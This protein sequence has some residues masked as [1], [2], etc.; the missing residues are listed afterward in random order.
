MSAET[1]DDFWAYK[2][3]GQFIYEPTGELWVPESVNASLP[4]VPL[5]D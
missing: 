5:V 2:P 1:I 3:S 4:R